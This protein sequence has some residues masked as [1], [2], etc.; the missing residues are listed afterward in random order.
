MVKARKASAK[1]KK[2]NRKT[3]AGNKSKVK[4][5]SIAWKS[6]SKTKNLGIVGKLAR[7]AEVVGDTIQET[8]EMRRKLGSR[9]GLSEG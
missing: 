1:A 9:G 4:R 2:S 7:A 3:K 5:R 6:R 8:S